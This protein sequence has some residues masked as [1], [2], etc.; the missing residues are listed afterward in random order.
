MAYPLSRG[1]PIAGVHFSLCWTTPIGTAPYFLS[2]ILSTGAW[3]SLD[4]MLL[5][6]LD[7]SY[8]TASVFY[9]TPI[10]QRSRLRILHLPLCGPTVSIG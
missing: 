8:A 7:Y 1:T 4:A 6:M 10:R 9:D 5:F 3:L 2:M